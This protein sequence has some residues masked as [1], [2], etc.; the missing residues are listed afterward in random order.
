[1]TRAKNAIYFFL[2]TAETVHVIVTIQLVIFRIN[3]IIEQ[4]YDFVTKV[5][6][7]DQSEV[8]NKKLKLTVTT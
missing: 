2:T 1:M 6:F 4:A 7:E 8:K 3:C 5:L